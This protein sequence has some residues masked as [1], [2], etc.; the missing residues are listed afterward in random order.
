MAGSYRAVRIHG[1][2]ADV[3]ER[4]ASV[5]SAV[6]DEC[7]DAAGAFPSDAH[8]KA[9]AFRDAAGHLR[10]A[11]NMVHE[12]ELDLRG[13]APCPEGFHG[14]PA[15]SWHEQVPRRRAHSPS[16][17]SRTD[18]AREALEA[19]A[20]AMLGD[21]GESGRWWHARECIAKASTSLGAV[22]YPGMF[23]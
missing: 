18:N 9:E 5:L 2:A 4:A 21:G 13:L 10:D 19:L 6:E 17:A 20:E 14:M 16:K 3:V 12:L 11:L 7:L 22:E 15:L 23:G 1:T 8:P